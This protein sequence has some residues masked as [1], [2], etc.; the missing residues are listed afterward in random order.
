MTNRR[1]VNRQPATS[2][3]DVVV[4]RGTPMAALTPVDCHRVFGRDSFATVAA[5]GH[6]FSRRRSRV[7]NQRTE[8]AGRGIAHRNS[9]PGHTGRNRC[10]RPQPSGFRQSNLNRVWREQKDTSI[11]LAKAERDLNRITRPFAAACVD[12]SIIEVPQHLNGQ[13][14]KLSPLVF[15]RKLLVGTIVMQRLV[16]LDVAAAANDRR[17]QA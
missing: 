9:A 15:R 16:L 12:A 17:D 13:A 7:I 5:Q 1:S 4:H 14:L 10:V 6:C 8:F 11:I 2:E 3:Y